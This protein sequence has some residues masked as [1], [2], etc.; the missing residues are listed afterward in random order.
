[1]YKTGNFS[2]KEFACKC[3]C[4]FDVVDAELVEVLQGVRSYFMEPVIITGPNRCAAHNHS[5]GG[6]VNSQHVL[7][8]AADF[9]VAGVS[10]D[11]VADYLE[12][13]YPDR[14]GIGRYDGR[15]HVDVR[16]TKARW[17]GD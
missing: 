6:A 2:R 17:N 8:K 12:R 10:A 15:T 4:G 16:E 1:M 11:Q 14:Y 9:R 3:G 5:I 7:G 13:T